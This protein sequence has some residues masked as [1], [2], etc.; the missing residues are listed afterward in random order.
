M[1]CTP[2]VSSTRTVKIVFVKFHW[3]S[4]QGVHGM[5][6]EEMKAADT[7]YATRDLYANIRAGAYPSGT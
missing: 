5:T 6:L 2:S 1:A 3:K 4:Q 7:S